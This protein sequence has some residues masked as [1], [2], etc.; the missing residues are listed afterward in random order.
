MTPVLLLLV[1]AACVAAVV[2]YFQ[3]QSLGSELR[4]VRN[5]YEVESRKIIESIQAELTQARAELELLKPLA[6]LQKSEAEV[7]ATLSAALD[8][9]EAMRKEAQKVLEQSNEAAGEERKRGQQKARELVEKAES[10]LSQATRDAGR[11]VSDAETR[12]AQIG[13]DAFLALREKQS[14]E[15]AI[16]AMRNIIEGYGDRY[17]IPTRSLLDEL[18]TYFGHTEAGE[19]LRAAREQTR[20]MLEHGEAAACDYVEANRRETAVRFVIDAFN[21]RVDAILTRTKHDNYGTLEQEIRDAFAL[22]NLHGEAFRNARVL[23]AYRD[24]RITE[25]R[26]AVAVQELKLKEREE[27]RRLQE[28]IREEERARREYERAI[29]EAAREEETIRTAMEKAR[30]EFEKASAKERVQLEAQL[31]QLNQ[32]LAEAE[33]KNQRAL[34]MAQ[35]TRSGNV[36]IISNVGSF[37]DE[38][39]KIGM[40]RR[41]EPQD[42]IKELSDASVPFDFDVHALIR[43]EDAPTL[44]RLLHGE[45]EEFRINKVNYRKEFFRVPLQRVREIVSERGLEAT[46]TMTAEAREYRETLALEKMTPEER[47]RYHFSKE[48]DD[49][50]E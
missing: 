33:L 49:S 22:V 25:L 8:D 26:W 15:S 50:P 39:L 21:G 47:H 43:S 27:Q 42:R 17:L 36:Y 32:R 48:E 13:G 3:K 2:L 38:I 19:A 16:K 28:K 46:F 29:Q 35:Q 10:L 37:G 7:R 31:A 11:I 6:A 34:S 14:I 18:A 44:E 24:G 41:L 45:L 23:P 20:R 5:H 4:R 9:A 40:T 12:A 30:A 1:A